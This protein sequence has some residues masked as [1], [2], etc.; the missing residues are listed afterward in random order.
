M[1]TSFRAAGVVTIASPNSG[2]LVGGNTVVI[3]GTGIG[4]GSDI[5]SVTL[6]GVTVAQILSQT[7][8]SVT[9]VAGDGTGHQGNGN[10]VL[11]STSVGTSTLTNGYT[12]NA[13]VPQIVSLHHVWQRA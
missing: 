3:N 8:D 6:N 7:T 13:G 2:P 11:Q 9:V 5:T 12:Y 10:I 1:L 4:S